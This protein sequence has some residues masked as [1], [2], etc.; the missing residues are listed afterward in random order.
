MDCSGNFRRLR[1]TAA[2]AALGWLTPALAAAEIRITGLTAD[3]VSVPLPATLARTA[4]NAARERP[5]VRVPAR[6][7]RLEISY[8]GGEPTDPAADDGAEPA[9]FA[10]GTRLR[11]RL[12]G[13]DDGWQDPPASGRVFLQFHDAA[14]RVV[15]SVETAM[16]GQSPGWTGSL[17]RSPFVDYS[18]AA[19][20]PPRA[21]WVTA[22]FLSHGVEAGRE[23]VGQIGIDAV[24]ITV[25]PPGGGEPVPH[26]LP[27]GAAAGVSEPLDTPTGW[28]RRGSWGRMAQLVGGGSPDS[29]LI[30]AIIDD[31]PRQYGNW[32]SVT[33]VPVAPGDAVVLGWRAAHSLGLGAAAGAEYRDL[34][35]GTLWFRAGTF[36]PAGD[37]TGDEASLGIELV[38]PWHERPQVLIGGLLAATGL[39]LAGGRSLALRRIK[40]R[41]EEVER[42]HAV[43]RERT[44][45]AR[46]LH[47]E[48]GAAL[49]EI[50]MQQYWV[51][52]EMEGV[53]PATTLARVEQSRQAVVDLVRNVDAI[54]WAVNPANDT[55]DR[56][57]PYLTHSVEQFL[58]SAGVAARIDAPDRPPPLPLEG[59]LRHGLFL[60]V[61]EAV[62]NAVKH[63]QPATVW[64][65]IHVHEDE[66]A[67]LRLSIVVADDGRGLAAGSP[68][69][70]A[71]PDGEQLA[72]AAENRLG[73]E[74]MRR[75]VAEA[76][77]W[78]TIEPRSH[79]GTAVTI[80]VP[81]E[82]AVSERF[83]PDG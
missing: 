22:H 75:R 9:T 12:D 65:T 61:R 6:T 43:E 3:G 24:V 2:A 21:A 74:S 1:L 57:I 4:A 71:P 70:A 42:A 27:V 36:R 37:P 76:G 45:I 11:H 58:E 15:D 28:T 54:V 48:V 33:R 67:R 14:E 8:A 78:L 31:D 17:E 19:T 80:D 20:A 73:I 52:R 83:R 46:D 34:P 60:T 30:L 5:L 64:L 82:P 50:A 68:A 53:A 66:A 69:A 18:L 72:S 77:G 79:G 49:T 55:L 39:A 7:R 44:R 62:N 13:V 63:G 51:Q 16:H 25:T 29:G 32:T 26:P 40:R 10:R 59:S 38:V 41:L 23:V 81:L 35:P 47:D 56:F